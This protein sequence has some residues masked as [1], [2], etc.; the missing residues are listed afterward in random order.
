M[1]R[2][3]VEVGILRRRAACEKLFASITCAKIISELRS[4]MERLSQIRERYSHFVPLVA[5]M[6]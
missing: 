5:Q 3:T 4:V 1:R 2:L 6:S